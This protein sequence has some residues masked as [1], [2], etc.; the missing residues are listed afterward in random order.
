M[1]KSYITRVLSDE[2]TNQMILIAQSCDL[3]R[4]QRDLSLRSLLVCNTSL[5]VKS[6]IRWKNL[7]DDNR[8][9][10]DLRVSSESRDLKLTQVLYINLKFSAV[11][12]PSN[13]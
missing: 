10:C 12:R 1:H 2:K 8:K 6:T 9:S 5:L 4:I 7:S 11:I 3:R 13:A